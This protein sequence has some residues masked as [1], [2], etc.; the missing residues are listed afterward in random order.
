[1]WSADISG[2][3]WPWFRS[4]LSDR[5]QYVDINNQPSG[6]LPVLS[7]VLQGSIFGPLLFLICINDI[8]FISI[9]N[10]LLMFADDTKCF[11]PVT[12]CTKEQLLQHDKN[13]LFHWSS[14][15]CLCLNPIKYVHIS[16]RANRITSYHL[17]KHAIPQ[18]KFSS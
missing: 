15:S 10:S 3:L 2:R 12:N 13:L 18:T 4:Y 17:N 14:R 9:H 6:L 5:S 7:G 8:F 11:G 16:F 1:M